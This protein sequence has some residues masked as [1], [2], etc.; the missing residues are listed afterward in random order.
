M[1]VG[2]YARQVAV[3]LFGNAA[4]QLVNLASYPAL[5]RLYTPADFGGF[6]LFLTAVG[7]LG[8]IACARFDLIIQSSKDWQLPAVFRLAMRLNLLVSLA[9]A[10]VLTAWSLATGALGLDLALLVAGGVFLTGYT[11][12]ALAVL[13]RQERY[14]LYSQ[15]LLARSLAT[16][17][18]Q[19]GLWLMFPQAFG[20]VLGFCLGFAV[21]ALVLGWGLRGIVWRRSAATHRRA[22]AARYRRQVMTDVPSTLIAGIALNVLAPLLLDLYSRAEVGF[23]SLAFRVAV[24]PLSLIAGSLSEVFFQKA[25]ESYRRTGRFWNEVRLNILS[26]AGLSLLIFVPMALLTR[27]VFAIAFGREWLP[28]ADL[29]VLLAPML[30]VRFIS[31]SIQT[32]PLVLGRAHWLL[33]QNVALIA[34]IGIAY[35]MAKADALPIQS[36]VLLTSLLMAAVYAGFIAFVVARTRRSHWQ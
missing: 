30:A 35:A 21:Q 14:R 23:Y 2:L 3:L 27:P 6:A 5:A 17:A 32:A 16:A 1:N 4:A 18:G 31:S 10:A 33:A 25:S 24:L 9:A 36:Y 13:V 20:L 28:A 11:L 12:A 22:I 26:T 15:S 8:P 19:I 7:I 29:L 34:A